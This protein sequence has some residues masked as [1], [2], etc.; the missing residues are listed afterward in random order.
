MKSSYFAKSAE[1]PNAVSIAC[2][3]PHWF[4]GRSYSKLAPTFD[5][6]ERYKRTGNKRQ[7]VLEYREQ[8]LS[9]LN[10]KEVFEELGDDAVLLCFEKPGNFCH[11]HL[12]TD[13]LEDNLNI[14]IEEI[15]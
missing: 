10:P 3:K 12:A 1:H 6:L 7:Y 4:K 9:K 8:V 11:R 13:W 2:F 14:L 15:K 5:I